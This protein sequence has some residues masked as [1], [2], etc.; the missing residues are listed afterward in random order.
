MGY[1]RITRVGLLSGGFFLLHTVIF[2]LPNVFPRAVCSEVA[3]FRLLLLDIPVG[4]IN[5]VSAESIS[6]LSLTV[7]GAFWA[8][9][10]TLVALQSSFVLRFAVGALSL[11]WIIA[12]SNILR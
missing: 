6:I 2:W 4:L 7:G 1:S 8:M 10:W 5:P 11:G 3:C 9:L 12:V